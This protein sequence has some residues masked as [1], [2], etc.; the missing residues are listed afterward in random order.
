[1]ESRGEGRAG[2]DEKEIVS[3]RGREGER[4]ERKKEEKDDGEEWKR[5]NRRI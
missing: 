3:V 4:E 5:G 2:N 1:M